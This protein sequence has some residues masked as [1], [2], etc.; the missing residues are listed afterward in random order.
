MSI[1]E[2]KAWLEGYGSSISGS[3][4]ADQWDAIKKKLST[5]REAPSRPTIH[6]LQAFNT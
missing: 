6:P 1:A 3:P 5:V 2:F 4:D